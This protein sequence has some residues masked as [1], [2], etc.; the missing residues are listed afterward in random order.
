MSVGRQRVV[1]VGSKRWL[2]L[3]RGTG[4]EGGEEGEGLRNVREA[5][6][7]GYGHELEVGEHR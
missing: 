4:D 1:R 3:N 7:T 5:G 2:C 6:I